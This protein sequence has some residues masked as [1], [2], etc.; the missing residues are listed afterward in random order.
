[1][2]MTISAA[3]QSSDAYN[4]SFTLRVEV[5][6][7]Q[8]SP[9]KPAMQLG[10]AA[11]I[12]AYLMMGKQPWRRFVLILSVT[13]AYRHLRV[14]M[15]NRSDGAVSTHFDIYQQLNLFSHIIAAINFGSLECVAYD[16]TVS[17]MKHNIPVGH[18]SSA[19]P[20]ASTSESITEL[21]VSETLSSDDHL[22]SA[23]ASEEHSSED[24]LAVS[25]NDTT[26]QPFAHEESPLSLALATNYGIHCPPSLPRPQNLTESI[27][28]IM[29]HPS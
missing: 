2:Y 26:T 10:K 13:N 25:S 9:Y 17:F 20:A 7:A 27:C 6:D 24:S 4:F 18:S 22:K 23:S 8:Y 29:H 19:D 14:L 21:L 12:H 3:H 28:T 5:G 1:M 16:S 11:D 15:Y